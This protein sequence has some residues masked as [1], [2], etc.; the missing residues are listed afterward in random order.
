M[1]ALTLVPLLSGGACLAA[2]AAGVGPPASQTAASSSQTGELD[3]AVINGEK[4]TRKASVLIEWIR[5]LP[6]KYAMEPD[7]IWIRYCR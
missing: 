5:R 4:P 6:G 3:E 2:S 1:I 7:Q